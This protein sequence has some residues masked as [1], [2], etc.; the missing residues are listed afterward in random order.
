M[1]PTNE[2][3]K[4]DATIDG[5]SMIANNLKFCHRQ[6]GFA[7]TVIFQV[8]TALV[9]MLQTKGVPHF[10]KSD[11]KTLADRLTV[12]SNPRSRRSFLRHDCLNQF[13]FNL[14]E[15][16]LI[17]SPFHKTPLQIP[18]KLIVI[19]NDH[20]LEHARYANLLCWDTLDISP[21]TSSDK[22][23]A[24]IDIICKFITS[25]AVHSIILYPQFYK[26]LLSLRTHQIVDYPLPHGVTIPLPEMKS[27]YRFFFSFPTSFYFYQYLYFRGKHTTRMPLNKH[28]NGDDIVTA[29]LYFESNDFEKIYRTWS[30]ERLKAH[31]VSLPD[32]INIRKLPEYVRMASTLNL[33]GNPDTI[34]SYPPYIL[35]IQSRMVKN[36]SFK[37]P[38]LESSIWAPFLYRNYANSDEPYKKYGLYYS[39]I[40]LKMLNDE[41]VDVRTSLMNLK[42][43][44]PIV[45][46]GAGDRILDI[47]M[48]ARNTLSDVDFNNF[49]LYAQWI[50]D[51]LL[52][53][54]RKLSIKSIN[55]YASGVPH[56]LYQLSNI[57]AVH[58]VSPD[59]LVETLGKVLAKFTVKQIRTSLK[60]FLAFVES[61]YPDQFQMPNWRCK[62][63]RKRDNLPQKPFIIFPDLTDAL[64][65]CFSV[66]S[67]YIRRYKDEHLRSILMERAR[68][69]ARIIRLMIQLSFYGGLRIGEIV[70][71]KLENI[72]YNNGMTLCIRWTKSRNGVRNIP[73]EVLSTNE[74]MLDF[75]NYYKERLSEA[76]SYGEYLFVKIPVFEGSQNSEN[77]NAYK[78][79]WDSSHVSSE[80]SRVFEAIGIAGIRFHELR[81][82][83]ANLLILRLYCIFYKSDI[84]ADVPLFQHALFQPDNLEKLRLLILGHDDQ[85]FGRESFVYLIETLSQALGHGSTDV[86]IERYLHVSDVIFYFILKRRFQ[87]YVKLYAKDLQNILN[88]SYPTLPRFMKGPG[89]KTL[90]TEDVLECMRE[91]LFKVKKSKRI[92]RLA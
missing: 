90:K 13:I 36:T 52:Q 33:T 26:D 2:M 23:E 62:E 27:F 7:T 30:S 34:Q 41:I 48:S 22:R 5:I 6:Y 81:H 8:A 91:R 71:L 20:L 58:S 65:Q 78:Y 38:F 60:D 37:Q 87:K 72:I 50:Q 54:R 88:I 45:K 67:A 19:Q 35:S 84:P 14:L 83:F 42:P 9:N 69:K 92:V 3:P 85:R 15:N 75:T 61:V 46:S 28:L 89:K 51:M 57:G 86:T 32:G 82:A 59:E 56:L 40:R 16:G 66:F 39:S 18:R 17:I 79:R 76:E 64:D 80:V 29:P 21:F 53:K 49:L 74:F 73:I 70:N 25:A 24:E 63:L 12:D 43:C 31:G 10:T 47:V 68:R 1:P 77:S 55:D 4:L 11:V 44:G